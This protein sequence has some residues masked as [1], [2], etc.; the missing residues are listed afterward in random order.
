MKNKTAMF[1][2]SQKVFFREL[3]KNITPDKKRETVNKILSDVTKS[4]R[5]TI[6]TQL[7]LSNMIL[8]N[9]PLYEIK[10]NYITQW[11][12]WFFGTQ[13]DYV[14]EYL[15]KENIYHVKTNFLDF[16]IISFNN[17]KPI[18]LLR[19]IEQHID[20]D[21]KLIESMRF[22][23]INLLFAIEMDKIDRLIITTSMTDTISLCFDNIDRW[24]K[25]SSYCSELSWISELIKQ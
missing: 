9:E 19:N 1:T 24:N 13:R 3:I 11:I 23:L 18:I 21:N 22:N 20:C 5:I 4:Y 6:M 15:V 2:E 14:K 25:Y 16:E 12:D 10:P 17:D 7:R 8:P